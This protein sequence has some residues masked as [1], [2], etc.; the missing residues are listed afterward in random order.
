MKRDYDRRQSALDEK[1]PIGKITTRVESFDK[2]YSD[3]EELLQSESDRFFHAY[4]VD[5]QAYH[6]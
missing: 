1:R 3:V 2:L 4:P 5:T 6:W